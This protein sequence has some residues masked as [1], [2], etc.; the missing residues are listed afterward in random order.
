MLSTYQ[1]PL[2]HKCHVTLGAFAGLY[3]SQHCI[4]TLPICPHEH[5]ATQKALFVSRLHG[6]GSVLAHI[7]QATAWFYA[8]SRFI[9]S[10]PNNWN[11]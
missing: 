8:C 1:R 9:V 5:Q 3:G 6:G 10:L 4:K 7:L 2:Q 11:K